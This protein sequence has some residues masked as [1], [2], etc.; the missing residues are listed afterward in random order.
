MLAHQYRSA[1]HWLLHK[2]SSWPDIYEMTRADVAIVV[3]RAD[4]RIRQRTC[5]VANTQRGFGSG[6]RKAG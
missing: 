3:S 1:L 2:M 4:E 5:G 6:A